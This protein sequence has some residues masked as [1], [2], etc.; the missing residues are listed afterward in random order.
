MVELPTGEFGEIIPQLV[1][2]VR[3]E[4]G[5]V[6][7]TARAACLICL[8]YICDEA[9]RGIWY[10][11]LMSCNSDP[12]DCNAKI[13]QDLDMISEEHTRLIIDV[14]ISV[15]MHSEETDV[16]RY[17]PIWIYHLQ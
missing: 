5:E 16:R 6:S 1:T 10:Q 13:V 11:R 17:V 15:G 2:A 8:G 7:T 4:G 9:V 14:M 3:N 12:F